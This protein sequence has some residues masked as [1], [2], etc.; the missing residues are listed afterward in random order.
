MLPE[1]LLILPLV[2][3]PVGAI[4]PSGSVVAIKGLQPTKWEAAVYP[5]EARRAGLSGEVVL[6]CSID[7]KGK[8]T[9]MKI[10][11][12]VSPLY[13]AAIFAVMEWRFDPPDRKG[14]ATSSGTTV[15]LRFDAQ[16][17]HYDG[18][19]DSLNSATDPLRSTAAQ[20]LGSLRPGADIS[21]D[22]VEA[23]LRRLDELATTDQSE[24]VRSTARSA[25]ARLRGQ[26]E[27]TG[28]VVASVQSPSHSPAGESAQAAPTAAHGA[29]SGIAELGYDQPPKPIRSP[30]PKYPLAAFKARI[31]GT[32]LVEVLIDA[33]GRVARS[34]VIQSVPGLDEGALATVRQWLF[35]PAVKNGQTVATL[36]HIPVHFRIY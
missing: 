36:A 12:G 17:F 21:A 14:H 11:T 33:R 19:M 5:E 26:P 31:E 25:A 13:E 16:P 3:S 1:L 23:A 4:A 22:E 34:R 10:L 20:N 28:R 2:G 29:Q 8:V 24:G 7:E 30:R 18:L 15:T 32:V 27:P 35:E 9:A 6:E